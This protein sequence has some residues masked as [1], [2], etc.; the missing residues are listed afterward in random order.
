MTELGRTRPLFHSE[1]D[2]QLALAW[3]IQQF[4]LTAAIRLEYRAEHTVRSYTDIWV[5]DGSRAFA[6]ELKYLTRAYAIETD[7]ERFSLSGQSAHDIRR[8]DVI[9]DLVRLERIASSNPDVAALLIVL[10]ND[11]A[12]WNDPRP[13]AQ[14]DRAFRLHEG[15]QL[16]GELTWSA[17]AGAG[18]TKGRE[19]PLILSGTYTLHWNDFADLG[20][21]GGSFRYLL[22][23]IPAE[24][25][26]DRAGARAE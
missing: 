25:V 3:T 23:E 24:S 10:S 12:Y 2:F 5:R 6:I 22:V 1:A 26:H 11:S 8:Y 15:R 17:A 4:Y 13:G 21:A 9:K 7:G 16:S 20:G 18:T 14:I 19:Q